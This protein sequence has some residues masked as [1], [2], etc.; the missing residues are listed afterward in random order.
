M[1]IRVYK[2]NTNIPKLSRQAFIAPHRYTKHVFMNNNFEQMI[3]HPL[4]KLAHLKLSL[5]A[6]QFVTRSQ[7]CHWLFPFWSFHK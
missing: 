2:E 3:Q 5:K 6:E 1:Y 7:L 4:L